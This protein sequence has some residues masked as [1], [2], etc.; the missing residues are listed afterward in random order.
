MQNYI[1]RLTKCGYDL[2]EARSLCIQLLQDSGI[3]ALS[4]FVREA[5]KNVDPV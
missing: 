1:N 5:E 4:A 2:F 3:Y